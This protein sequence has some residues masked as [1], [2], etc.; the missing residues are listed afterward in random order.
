MATVAS[1]YIELFQLASAG[2]AEGRG[3]LTDAADLR[4]DAVRPLLVY[5]NQAFVSG[6]IQLEALARRYVSSPECS[7]AAS[8]KP[9]LSDPGFR[10]AAGACADQLDQAAPFVGVPGGRIASG[11]RR[12]IAETNPAEAHTLAMACDAAARMAK[13]K[14]GRAA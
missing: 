12:W 8:A 6:F 3:V 10:A 9:I 7:G 11:L 4:G 1:P 13:M 14:A 2:I 5:A